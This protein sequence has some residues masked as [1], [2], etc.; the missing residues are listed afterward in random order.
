M[1]IIANMLASCN[2][3]PYHSINLNNLLLRDLRNG[4]IIYF[5]TYMS[6]VL[7]YKSKVVSGVMYKA[8]RGARAL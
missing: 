8:E 7:T 3:T 4:C 6:M 2:G 1:Y 5:N